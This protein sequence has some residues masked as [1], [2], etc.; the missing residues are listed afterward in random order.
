MIRTDIFRRA[1]PWSRLIIETRHFPNDLNLK[2]GQRLSF[3]LLTIACA[4]LLASVARPGLFVLALAILFVVLV[5][6]RKLYG[7]FARE[8]GILFAA[9]CI[10]L[11]LL[12]YLYSGASYIW[13]WLNSALRRPNDVSGN[14]RQDRIWRGVRQVLG[15]VLKSKSSQA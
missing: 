9:A 6:N 1:I 4:F 8:R 13:V 12:Y 5:F 14:D 15:S 2:L 11:H 10:P 7:F 3:I